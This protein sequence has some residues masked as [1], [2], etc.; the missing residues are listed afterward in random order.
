MKG[1]DV[2]VPILI[3]LL[4]DALVLATAVVMEATAASCQSRGLV[5]ECRDRASSVTHATIR[6]LSLRTLHVFNA[7][8]E[9]YTTIKFFMAFFK[10]FSF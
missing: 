6:A 1:L 7:S 4:W 5:S 10:C 9:T 3:L 8:R 2:L